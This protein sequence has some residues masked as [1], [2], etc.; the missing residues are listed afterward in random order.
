MEKICP[1]RLIGKIYRD[2]SICLETQCELWLTG[3]NRCSLKLLAL[4]PYLNDNLKKFLKQKNE[5]QRKT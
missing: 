2:E 3:Y 1:F 4:L 5:K